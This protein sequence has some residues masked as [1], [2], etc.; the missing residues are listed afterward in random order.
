MQNESNRKIFRKLVS[1]KEACRAVELMKETV[2]PE[3]EEIPI[4]DALNRVLAEDIYSSCDIPPFDR[5][6]MDGYAVRAEDTFFADEENPA[7]LKVVGEVETGEKPEVEVGR[8]EA[9]RI[10]TGAMMP[11]NAN[12]V[13]MVEYT[14]EN[15]SGY[16]EVYRGV[17]PGENVIAAGSDVM[18]GELIAR[19]HT[20]ISAREAGMLAAV[21]IGKVKVYRKPEVAI[22]ST[23]NELCEWG[24]ALE[25]GKIYD[26]NSATL[27]LAVEE[28]GGVVTYRKTVRDDWD[29]MVEAVEEAL[30]KA[31]VVIMSGG[32]S[33]GEGDIVYRVLEKMGNVIVHGIAVKPGKPAVFAVIRE[34]PVFGLP[35]YPTS[36]FMIFD[37]FVAPLIRYLSGRK[38]VRSKSVKANLAVR[39]VSPHGRREFHPVCLVRGESGYSAYPLTGNYS[40]MVSKLYQADGF[41]EIGE[42]VTILEPGEVEVTLFSTLKPS[43]LVVIGSH[44]IGVDLLVKLAS[45]DAKIINAGSTGGLLAVKRGEAD[46]A[47]THLLDESGEYNLPAMKKLGLKNA[48][49]IK[50]YLREQGLIVGKG[51]PKGIEWFDDMLREDVRVINRNPGSGTRVLMDMHLKKIAGERGK[52]FDEIVKRING[53]SVEAKTHTAVAVAVLTGKADVGLGIKSVADLYGLDFI[54]VRAEEYDFAVRK[55]RLEKGAVKKFVETLKSEDFARELEAIGMKVWERTGEV[56]E[57]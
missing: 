2:K 44:C 8:G 41:I 51:N 14:S 29:S 52:G 27:S 19:K 3:V 55:D 33:A 21:G 32:T 12:A 16:V 25:A 7:I 37:K 49:L 35:G 40:A 23:G 5:A 42:D 11:P 22:I 43:E 53:Y 18:A 10:S 4:T 24:R 30:N 13:V 28:C 54:P 45:V 38:E 31:E 48:V 1:V 17:A 56:I 34:K 9:V 57:L 46:I 20:V 15:E 39:V 26:V 36:A 6:A 47:G 50:G